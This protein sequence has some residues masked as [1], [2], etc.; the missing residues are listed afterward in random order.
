MT[1]VQYKAMQAAGQIPQTI[2]VPNTALTNTTVPFAGSAISRQARRLYV[3]NIPFGVTEEA[4][5][6]FFNQQMK[7]SGLA[8][9]EGDPVIAVQINLDKNFAFL[10]FR[11]VDE[12]TQAMAF[13]GINFQGQSLKIRRPRDYQVLPGMSENPSINVPGVVSTV[14]QDSPNKIF[15]GGLPN[16]LNEDQV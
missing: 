14:V 1:P 16:Y 6:D 8:Q 9:A 13:D 10:E 7:I 11:S 12:T 4:M 3:G 15:L 5:R 2:S